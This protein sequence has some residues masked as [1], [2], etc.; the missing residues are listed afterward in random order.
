MTHPRNFMDYITGIIVDPW[1]DRAILTT[2]MHDPPEDVMLTLTRAKGRP[3]ATEPGVFPTYNMN[4]DPRYAA[5]V[6]TTKGGIR[7]KY[8]DTAKERRKRIAD[9]ER[10]RKKRKMKE[11]IT[12][13]PLSYVKDYVIPWEWTPEERARLEEY[14]SGDPGVDN[15]RGD[16]YKVPAH[17][18]NNTGGALHR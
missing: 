5:I 1:D 9:L 14:R 11:A 17:S 3:G 6:E 15:A 12:P 13:R 18:P 10:E 8:C 7:R 16:S 4:D 2:V